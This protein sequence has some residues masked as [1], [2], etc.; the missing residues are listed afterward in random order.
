MSFA[1]GYYYGKANMISAT[2]PY[3]RPHIQPP[4]RDRAAG[5][6]RESS[7]VRIFDQCYP[8]NPIVFGLTDVFGWQNIFQMRLNIDSRPEKSLYVLLHG[9]TLEIASTED[10]IYSSS[11]DVLVYPPSGR[12]ASDSIGAAVDVA[13]QCACER[14]PVLWELSIGHFWPGALMTANNHGAQLT[15][16]YFQTDRRAQSS[17]GSCAAAEGIQ[18]LEVSK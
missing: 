9:K 7:V 2:F 3:Q 16:A 5:V 15:L 1:L 12:F 17:F 13:L 8:S 14:I 4:Q 10:S 18:I 11:G 6:P